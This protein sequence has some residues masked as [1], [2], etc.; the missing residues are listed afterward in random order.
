MFDEVSVLPRYRTVPR[1][2]NSITTE[3]EREGKYFLEIVCCRS[4]NGPSHPNPSGWWIRPLTATTKTMVALPCDI[5]T[6]VHVILGCLYG[7][8]CRHVSR[9]CPTWHGPSIPGTPHYMK[10]CCCCFIFATKQI[11]WKTCGKLAKKNIKR[12]RL[13]DNLTYLSHVVI[14]LFIIIRR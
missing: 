9:R 13:D 7:C 12:G 2:I 11:W 5:T 14:N 1:P 8:K 6:R 10:F 3:S 4:W